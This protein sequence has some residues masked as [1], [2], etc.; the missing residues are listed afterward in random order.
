[1][2]LHKFQ[3]SILK[4]M[5]LVTL[6]VVLTS[7]APM[8]FIKPQL[9]TQESLAEL[10]E[11][12]LRLRNGMTWSGSEQA[13]YRILLGQLLRSDAV[14]VVLERFID[15]LLQP[16]PSA[17]GSVLFGANMI[18]FADVADDPRF[19]AQV[20]VGSRWSDLLRQVALRYPFPESQPASCHP[21]AAFIGASMRAEQQQ[22]AGDKT[23][24]VQNQHLAR[25]ISW[26]R[27]ALP[28]LIRI[29]NQRPETFHRTV[30]GQECFSRY[31]AAI[32]DSLDPDYLLERK[33]SGVAFQSGDGHQIVGRR[34]GWMRQHSQPGS[35]LWNNV[36]ELMAKMHVDPIPMERSWYA[37]EVRIINGPENRDRFEL[38][39]RQYIFR[40][41]S[42]N[43][44]NS[45]L[46]LNSGAAGIPCQG[47]GKLYAGFVEDVST[48]LFTV[49]EKSAKPGMTDKERWKLDHPL[50]FEFMFCEP[51]AH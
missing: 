50:V 31:A 25:L 21:V 22:L 43:R 17:H 11:L 28:L 2:N 48:G 4:I 35:E 6:V 51:N 16:D 47:P 13:Q 30:A 44:Y 23:P 41:G 9:T 46:L 7:C 38:Q 32:A 33:K 1:M 18:V 49:E 27:Q 5:S 29:Y 39:D 12:R 24:A 34:I 15:D 20:M 40:D 3:Y 36:E 26:R 37:Q 45:T 19:A 10:D 42:S 8:G 14:P